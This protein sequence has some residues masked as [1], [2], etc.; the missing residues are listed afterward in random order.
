MEI[1]LT[2]PS[3]HKKKK[4]KQNYIS[5]LVFSETEQSEVFM[6]KTRTNICQLNQKNTTDWQIFVN[7]NS[8]HLAQFYIFISIKTSRFLYV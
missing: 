4:E 1:T 6:I 5:N 7:I 2:V 3:N 8:P